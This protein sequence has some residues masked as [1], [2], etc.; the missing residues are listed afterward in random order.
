MATGI[1]GEC[2]LV[3][4]QTSPCNHMVKFSRIHKRRHTGS[5]ITNYTV[6]SIEE[7]VSLESQPTAK[8]IVE[9]KTNPFILITFGVL[10]ILAFFP[11]L[12]K[13]MTKKYDK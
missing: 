8:V 9:T 10:E 2:V 3:S 6:N 13:S 12:I 4:S 1:L 7:R 5:L 11:S